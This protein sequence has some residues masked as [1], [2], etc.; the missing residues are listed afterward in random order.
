MLVQRCTTV[1]CTTSYNIHPPYDGAVQ[2]FP[3]DYRQARVVV[4]PFGSLLFAFCSLRFRGLVCGG[5]FL[6]KKCLVAWKQSSRAYAV[7]ARSRRRRPS[8][9]TTRKRDLALPAG[10]SRW[11]SCRWARSRPSCPPS[12]SLRRTGAL[13]RSTQGLDRASLGSSSPGTT[14]D[15]EAHKA[16]SGCNDGVVQAGL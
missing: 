5:P 13:C 2:R 3:T 15:P 7:L 6:N 12:R 16:P 9:R 8:R 10:T 11:C 4:D 1:H 14:S